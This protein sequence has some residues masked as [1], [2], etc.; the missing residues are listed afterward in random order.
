MTR[1]P[2]REQLTDSPTALGTFLMSGSPRVAEALGES[3]LGYLVV[4]RQ[5]AATGIETVEAIV[6]A[7]DAADLPTLV[8]LSGHDDPYVNGVLDAGADGVLIPGVEDPATV[9]DVVRRA[10]YSGERSLALGTRAGRFGGHDRETHLA[11]AE[12]APVVPQVETAAGLERVEAIAGHDAVESVFVGP[13]DLA[14]SLD[15]PPGGAEVGEAVETVVAAAHDAGRGA[16]V[17]AGS[18]DAVADY[19]GRV[20]YV[21]YG[22]DLG[23]VAGGVDD[24]AGT[25]D[26]T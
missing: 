5:H 21:V 11:A 14:L 17:F 13:N 25:L 22:A 8:R 4:D 15:V 9:D 7:A 18:P 24:V 23:L 16:G 3:A 10:R 19:A 20:E 26:G 6:R 2:L 1:P 12:R